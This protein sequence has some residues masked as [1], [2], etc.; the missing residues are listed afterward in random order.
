MTERNK[1]NHISK[2]LWGNVIQS[3]LKVK[4]GSGRVLI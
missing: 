4:G 3:L 2:R 1:L